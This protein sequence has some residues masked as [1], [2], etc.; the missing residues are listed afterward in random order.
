MGKEKKFII[1][2]LLISI[3]FSLVTIAV[4]LI[5]SN[6]NLSDNK[7]YGSIGNQVGNVQ[8]YVEG[9]SEGENNG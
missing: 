9:N 8:L 3:V 7:Y 6:V 4:N 2:L 5:N 1:V